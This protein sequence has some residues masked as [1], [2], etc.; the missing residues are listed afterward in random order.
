MQSP[1]IAPELSAMPVE[2]TPE[3]STPCDYEFASDIHS[4]VDLAELLGKTAKHALV[5]VPFEAFDLDHQVGVGGIAELWLAHHPAVEKPFVVK[6]AHRHL[7]DN[8]HVH[9]QFD[10]EWRA[11]RI[12]DHPGIIKHYSRGL[13][14]DGRPFLTMEVVVG[15]SLSHFVRKDI[16]WSFLRAVL[17]QLCDVL[18]HVHERGLLH[19]D[20]KPSN[21][22]V[23]IS[24]RRIRLTDFGLTRFEKA[25]PGATTASVLG[26]PAYMA[27]EQARGQL[28][29]LGAHTDLYTVGVV[30][31]EL[32]TGSK[33]F[34]VESDRVVM[35]KHCTEAPR[36]P[37]IR[38]CIQAPAE[39][40]DV[41]DRLLAKSPAAR[42][43]SARQL[44]KTLKRMPK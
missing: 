42:Y 2:E 22:L 28:G 32:L 38:D 13:S 35:I 8:L 1:L 24:K 30:L 40:L 21:V 15:R 33:P 11:T 34:E 9:A 27:P 23:D 25:K 29:E 16:N 41:L 44:K 18:H 10:R 31:Y 37:V 19:Q 6:V 7:A 5:G 43:S 26:T 3:S 17:I 12:L 39:I 14:E 20:L 4:T 36:P